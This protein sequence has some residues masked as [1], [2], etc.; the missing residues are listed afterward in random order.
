MTGTLGATLGL[1][2]A[3]VLVVMLLAFT[4]GTVAG[5][6]NVADVAWGIGFAA[7]AVVA[8]IA[9]AGHGDGT[10]RAL[11][12][13]ATVIWGLRL[14]SHIFLRSRGRGEDPRYA[15]VLGKARGNRGWYA[16]RTVYLAQGALIWVISLP[17]QAGMSAGRPLAAPMVAG[18]LLW[19]GGLFFEAVGDRQLETFKS[20]PANRGKIMDRGLWRYTRHP[21]YFGD[22]CVWWG[23]FLI[24]CGSWVS[25][26]TVI[27]PLLMTYLLV[28]G[29]GKRL[30]E[31]RM[32][33]SRPGYAQYA[34]RTSGF[35][36]LPPRTPAGV[37]RAPESEYNG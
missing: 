15:A 25:A 28:W 2:A 35:I 34:A 8:L 1:S 17:V 22:A 27:S 10:R 30:A 23:I 9:S 20:D 3:A 18:G 29:S 37:A 4:A 31:K 6:H 36:P 12:A 5:R 16:L 21:N 13:A 11:L 26:A 32:A 33:D 19:L 14:A 24:A 7:V